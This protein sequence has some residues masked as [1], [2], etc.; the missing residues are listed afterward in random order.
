MGIAI[1][2]ELQHRGAEVTLVTGPVHQKTD[3][4]HRIQVTTA[5]EMY[6][7]CLAQPYD[8]AV[9]AAAVADY[10]PVRPA[11]KKIKKKDGEL[12][13]QLAR[14]KDILAALGKQKKDG[15]VLVGF[16]LETDNERESA[17][18]KLNEKGADLIVM[19]SLQD[20][21]AGFGHD[22]NKASFFLRN[23]EEI[24][25]PL[26]SKKA[27]AKEIVDTIITLLP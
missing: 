7:A 6:E 9:M 23:G 2:T 18:K 8:M 4:I 1:A 5:A 10:T 15:Q 19:N 21:G 12:L 16:A 26:Q 22:T 3:G 24:S 11:D 14:T 17:L 27:L 13:L 20:E 25:L